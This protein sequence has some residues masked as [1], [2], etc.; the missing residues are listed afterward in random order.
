MENIRQQYLKQEKILN[1]L[2]EISKL[3]SD[4]KMKTVDKITK[5]LEIYRSPA[6]FFNDY[7]IVE[8][9]I[10]QNNKNKKL[11]KLLMDTT[12]FVTSVF[13]MQKEAHT[14]KNRYYKKC[15]KENPIKA[16]KIVVDFINDSDDIDII[17]SYIYSNNLFQEEFDMAVKYVKENDEFIYKQYE[18][19]IGYIENTKYERNTKKLK[20]IALGIK[21]GYLSDGT[22][23]DELQFWKLAPF[24]YSK[25]IV[26]DFK[27]FREKNPNIGYIGTDNFYR[28]IEA[29]GKGVIPE[30]I[31]IVLEYMKKKKLNSYTYLSFEGY[32][33]LHHGFGV[34]LR[35]NYTKTMTGED[36]FI[37]VYDK[38]DTRKLY[39]KYNLT[40]EAQ[41]SI[42]REVLKEKLPHTIEVYSL[43]EERY[44]LKQIDEETKNKTKNKTINN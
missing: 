31:D 42:L 29:F 43:L 7:I 9:F 32:K 38:S 18:E 30:D 10:S 14:A 25:G 12:K 40:S 41:R 28:R 4:F 35:G 19:K 33:K 8:D 27:K 3:Q 39:D 16:I 17:S 5:L 23:F 37:D 26:T 6:D 15:F 44:I 2:I 11:M 1:N 34:N 21:T 22:Q 24:M 20:E 13:K 36:A